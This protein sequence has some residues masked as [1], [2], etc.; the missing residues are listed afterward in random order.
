[1]TQKQVRLLAVME[2]VGEAKVVASPSSIR[3]LRL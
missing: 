2:A 1:M 3:W